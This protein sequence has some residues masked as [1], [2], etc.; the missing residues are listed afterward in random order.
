MYIGVDVHLKELTIAAIDEKL[1]I[2]FFKSVDKE[3]FYRIVK[4]YNPKII[5]IDAPSML[6]K[7]FMNDEGYRANLSK[8]IKGHFNKKVSEYELSR[9]NIHPFSTPGSL[10][11]AKGWKNWMN[12]GF[13]IF[14]KLSVMGYPLITSKN[15]G[16]IEKGCHEVF[17][18]A[19]FTTL[20]GYIPSNKKKELGINERIQV[21]RDGG[22]KDLCLLDDVKK[23]DIADV[24]DA[25][26]AAYS[27]FVLDSGGAIFLG[28]YREAE[29]VVPVHDIKDSYRYK[30]V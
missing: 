26:I 15:H 5:S 29:V 14:E 16:E 30:K 22:V 27:G 2:D 1:N 17:P 8:N 24:L 25:L 19:S 6:N 10:E 3:E 4:E 9:R 7:G 21:L 13:M 18:H 28:D 20:L 12:N 23:K 11:D